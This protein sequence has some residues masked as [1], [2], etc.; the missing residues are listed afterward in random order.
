MP[1]MAAHRDY[2]RDP[3]RAIE[4]RLKTLLMAA[5]GSLASAFWKP[6]MFVGGGGACW[7]PYGIA[8]HIISTVAPSL[9]STDVD[10]VI[11]ALEALIAAERST[12]TDAVHLA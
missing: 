8:G 3:L 12:A 4:R 6:V 11:R 10:P 1:R 7:G 2:R 9:E 5:L